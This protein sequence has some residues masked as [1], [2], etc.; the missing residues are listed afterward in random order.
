MNSKL[1]PAI[2]GGVVVGLLSAI[3]F[4]N[5]PNVCCCLWAI[6]GG[7]IASYVYIKSSPTPVK[8]GEGAVLGVLAGLVGA[9]IYIVIGIPLGILAGSALNGLIVKM[10]ENA[11]P[12]SARQMQRQMANQSILGSVMFGFIW[13]LLL[14]LFSTLGGLVGVPIFEKRKGNP[15]PPPPPQGFGGVQPGSGAAA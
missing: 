15:N 1:K 10:L 9:A 14:I 3:P 5:I 4:V 12:S 13:A 6:L 11:D 2:I 7:A 8:A